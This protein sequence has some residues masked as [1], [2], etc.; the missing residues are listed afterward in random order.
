MTVAVTVNPSDVVAAQNF[1]Q[2]YL[3]D[4]VPNGDFSDGTALNDLCVNAIAQIFAFLQADATQIRQMQSLV[5]IQAA[6]GGDTEALAD[7]VTG[8]ASNFL[9][10]PLA[11]TYASGFAIGHATAQVD[12]F[13]P[14]TIQFTYSPGI[15]FVVNSS[16]TLYI[17]QASLVP[18]V[19][20]NGS[21]SEY[22]FRI[23]LI[24]IATGT[25]YNVQPAMFSAFDRFNPYVT[26]IENVDASTAL[27][28]RMPTAISVRNLI[29]PRSIVATLNDNFDGIV[30]ILVIGM[31][32][33][34]MQRDVV[35]TSAPYLRFHVG[36]CVDIYLNLALVETTFTAAVGAPFARP[37]GVVTIF[38]DGLTSF[39][40]VIPGDII[41]ITAGLPI[42]PAQFLV[43][44]IVNGTDLIVS[45]SAPFPVATDEAMPPTTVSYTVGNV[46]PLFNNHVS[47]VGGIPLTT[48]S[49][50]RTSATSG[51]ITMPGSPIMDILDVA[52]LNPPA[53]ES[54]FISPLDG[55]EH[56][57][58]QV[59]HTPQQ[60][61]TPSAG[62]Q[63]QTIVHNPPYAQSSSQ[64]MEIVV[65]TDTVQ[66]RFD[67]LN[68]RVLYRTIDQ[69]ASIDTFVRGTDERVSAASQLPRAH[70]PVVVGMNII[71]RLL[72]NA[73]TLLDNTAIAQ[74]VVDYINAF[75]SSQA[76][77]DC[78]KIIQLVLDNY[79]TIAN[80]VPAVPNGPLLTIT[81]DLR[82][83]TGD[84]IS[85]QTTDTVEVDP[86]KQVAGPVLDLPALGVTNR[87]M[88]YIANTIDVTAQQEG[89]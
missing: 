85:Y 24:A 1:L 54:A 30:A 9:V 79:P 80:I 23:P 17:P 37:D 82:A 58:N 11:G 45:D 31:G 39:A 26:F 5:T 78:S 89:T 8:I 84:V 20:T 40:S 81:Y 33:P 67:G 32:D 6:T 42:V 44:E 70:N 13:I 83:P 4:S 50:S 60:S 15:V 71:Y 74:T 57:P 7:A 69:F 38:R 28:A 55:F 2:Q 64:W 59:D 34:E 48:G 86:T 22:Q 46:G 87:T 66:S 61:A 36:G 65:G 25:Q 10:Q 47:G 68:L 43:I 3:T 53:G 35:P 14:T 16:D 77:I 12:V 63:F 52:I 73:T 27:I 18:I 88:R 41:S 29:N 19:D 21:I 51:R 76:S 72:A 75:D 56:F 62:L 49:T